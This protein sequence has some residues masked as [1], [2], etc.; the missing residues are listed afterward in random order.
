MFSFNINPSNLH[1]RQ[2]I[3]NTRSFIGQ[4]FICLQFR[5]TC[6]AARFLDLVVKAG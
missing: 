4:R 1:D 3:R 5:E 2:T 6:I